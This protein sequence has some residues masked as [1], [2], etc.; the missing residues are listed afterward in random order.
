MDM[1]KFFKVMF[2]NTVKVGI[3]KKIVISFFSI[4]LVL[5]N[6]GIMLKLEVYLKTFEGDLCHLSRSYPGRIWISQFLRDSENWV[7]EPKKNR[8]IA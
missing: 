3:E 7:V 4:S 6:R 5:K 1:F 8:G 2:V